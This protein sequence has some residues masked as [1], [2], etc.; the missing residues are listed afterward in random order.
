[1]K[2]DTWLERASV[3]SGDTFC[4]GA[5][6]AKSV[7]FYSAFRTAARWNQPAALNKQKPGPRSRAWPDPRH[8]T[9]KNAPAA[10]PLAARTERER[11]CAQRPPRL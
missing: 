3:T 5:V 2:S 8:P 6:S 7:D 10:F 9:G 11:T 1:M 4:V